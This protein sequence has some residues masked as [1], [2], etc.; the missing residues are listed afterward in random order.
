[1]YL[2]YS[3]FFIF[4]HTCGFESG[5]T[6]THHVLPSFASEAVRLAG[7]SGAPL[8]AGLARQQRLRAAGAR[9]PPGQVPAVRG[10]EIRAGSAER[11]RAVGA[12]AVA[13]HG[14]SARACQV[15][16]PLITAMHFHNCS[17]IVFGI[18]NGQRFSILSALFPELARPL[19]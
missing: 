18:F 4:Q 14:V 11:H 12:P 6:P 1:M 15:A 8:R 17:K 2:Q 13:R 7:G 19:S 5:P 16:R 3:F 10:G 9:R